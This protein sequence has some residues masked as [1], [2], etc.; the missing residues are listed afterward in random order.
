MNQQDDAK[1]KAKETLTNL[2]QKAT[3]VAKKAASEV[4][5]GVNTLSEK[6][7]KNFHEKRVE[8]Y[9]PLFAK[10]YKSKSFKIPNVIEIVDDAVRRKIDICEGAIGWLQDHKGVEVLHL[11]DEY[12]SKCGLTFIPTAQ[13]DS[14]YCVDSFD[15]T[16]FINTNYIFAKTN[17][18]KLA[19]L[20]NIAHSLGAK[21]CSIEMLESESEKNTKSISAKATI[22]V[23]EIKGKEGYQ[24]DISS[25]T[26][27]KSSGKRVLNFTG[28]DNPVRP[29]LKWFAHDENVKGLIEMRCTDTNSIKSTIL[30]ISG[31]NHVTMSKKVACAID[32][33]AN[34]KIGGN[35]EMSMESQAVKEHNSRLIF[36]IEF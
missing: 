33:V 15:R 32:A 2:W 6:A 34:K 14:I 26:A 7:Q 3:D 27:A 8:K 30:D 12:L 29:T 20:A 1:N 21:S 36:E 13:C 16:Q 22:N 31:S 5:S 23:G 28:S 24:Y 35:A 17:E 19:E 11:Y 25:T 18:E 4:Q 10:E 9:R